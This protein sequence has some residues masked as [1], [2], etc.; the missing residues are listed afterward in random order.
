MPLQVGP[1]TASGEVATG[2]VTA[3]RRRRP[4]ARPGS[5]SACSAQPRQAAL[6]PKAP[7]SA[8]N[9]GTLTA[10]PGRI[11]WQVLLMLPRDA[12]CPGMTKQYGLVCKGEVSVFARSRCD[13]QV[14][15]SRLLGGGAGCWVP[16]QAAAG[17]GRGACA[18]RSAGR[19][20]VL[21]GGGRLLLRRQPGFTQTLDAEGVRFVLVLEAQQN[22]PG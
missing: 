4:A 22:T 8:C 19:G 6:R 1:P 14:P 16:D 20:A 10:R 9:G 12:G 3:R 21:G 18:G 17:R 7:P 2:R 11:G 13:R 5:A 15:A